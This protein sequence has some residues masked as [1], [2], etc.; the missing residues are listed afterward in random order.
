MTRGLAVWLVIMA[1][2]TLHGVLRGLFLVPVTG[3]AMASRIGWP[4]GAMLVLGLTT[5]L[6]RWT[7]LKDMRSLLLL[8]LAWAALTFGFEIA[9]GILRGLGPAQIIA[10]IDPLSGGL[11]VYSLIVV[12]LAPLAAA[13]L[14]GV[15]S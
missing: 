9:I 13:R 1:A 15:L 4:I 7:G 5:A 8:G 14:R 6:I 2:E 12:A 11:L 3:E 10:E